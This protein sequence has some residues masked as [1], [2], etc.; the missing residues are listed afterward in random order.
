MSR[1]LIIGLRV[2]FDICEAS[3]SALNFN[4]SLLRVPNPITCA[5]CLYVDRVSAI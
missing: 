1:T 3:T 4:H 2:T 5:D